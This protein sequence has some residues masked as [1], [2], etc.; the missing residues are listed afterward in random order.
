MF[1]ADHHTIEQ[2]H[3][4]TQAIHLKRVWRRAQAIVLAKQ[5]RTAQE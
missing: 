2:L 3:E 1:V 4:L 5:G